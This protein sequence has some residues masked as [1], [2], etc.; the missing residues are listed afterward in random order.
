MLFFDQGMFLRVLF[1]VFAYLL[2]RNFFRQYFRFLYL[3][4][5][6]ALPFSCEYYTF[7]MRFWTVSRDNCFSNSL[8]LKTEAKPRLPSTVTK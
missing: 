2:S 4:L 6:T 3:Y 1:R 8:I 5:R 7:F